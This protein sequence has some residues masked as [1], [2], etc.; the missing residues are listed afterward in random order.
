MKQKIV[1]GT[2]KRAVLIIYQKG[3]I[4][5]N[6]SLSPKGEYFMISYKNCPDGR[7]TAYSLAPMRL[8]PQSVSYKSAA[9]FFSVYILA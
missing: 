1:A 8:I 4:Y 2:T 7:H 5:E 3:E 6:I 9:D